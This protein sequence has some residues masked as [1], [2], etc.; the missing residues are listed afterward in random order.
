MDIKTARKVANW[1]AYHHIGVALTSGAIGEFTDND[2][3]WERIENELKK[4]ELRLFQKGKY[5]PK[6]K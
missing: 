5:K 4:I 6:I 3:D 1:I 2:K